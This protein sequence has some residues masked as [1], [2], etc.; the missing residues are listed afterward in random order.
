M[1]DHEAKRERVM[2][3]A[4]DLTAERDEWRMKAEVNTEAADRLGRMLEEAEAET[5]RLREENRQLA[6]ERNIALNLVQSR[7]PDFDV[8]AARI[9]CEQREAAD[10]RAE[11]F[12]AERDALS[13][14]LRAVRDLHQPG[15]IRVPVF[16]EFD[17]PYGRGCERCK[18]GWPC[19]TIRALDASPGTPGDEK[20]QVGEPGS[21][22]WGTPE[23]RSAANDAAIAEQIVAWV[24][25]NG[26]EAR[27][28]PA[29]WS[30]QGDIWPYI[31]VRTS[32][33][34]AYAKPGDW[35]VMGDTWFQVGGFKEP[36]RL[37]REF[38]VSPVKSS[39]STE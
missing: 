19:A 28:E 21:R 36:A 17:S 18:T 4:V 23:L 27:Y 39:G 2:Q 7:T 10:R 11:A 8:V 6:A 26:G 31:V 25:A 3:M 13:A 30:P 20:P 12:R 16:D 32:K 38:T 5:A 15:T 35:I 29:E 37:V 1:T 24:N 34:P 9:Q 22:R 33:G 14:R